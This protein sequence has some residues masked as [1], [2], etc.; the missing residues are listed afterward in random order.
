MKCDHFC[1]HDDAPQALSYLVCEMRLCSG[2]LGIITVIL[3][4]TNYLQ[5]WHPNQVGIFPVPCVISAVRITLHQEI[6]SFIYLPG[7][8]LHCVMGF[9]SVM[10][11]ISHSEM[12]ETNLYI[13]QTKNHCQDFYEQ[14]VR[15]CACFI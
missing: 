12:K 11:T 4:S 6:K 7:H 5:R 1:S 15:Q 2:A 3:T 8:Y 14:R 10:E 13:Q 9:W